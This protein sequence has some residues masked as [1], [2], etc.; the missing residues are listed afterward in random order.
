MMI[1]NK[2]ES[3]WKELFMAQSKVIFLQLPGRFKNNHITKYLRVVGVLSEIRIEYLPNTG[4]QLH[5]LSTLSMALQSIVG[6][7]PLF[8][9][10][11]PIQ[12]R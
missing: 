3:V 5:Y 11:D 1:N 4:D 2:L 9:F 7:W 12:S 8:Q 6:L 10:L